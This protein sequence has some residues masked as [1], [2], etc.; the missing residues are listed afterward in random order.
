MWGMGQSWT[1][2]T[3]LRDGGKY[4]EK[5]IGRHGKIL[6]HYGFFYLKKVDFF[7]GSLFKNF[8]FLMCLL[9]KFYEY[10]IW[11]QHT[12]KRFSPF[13]VFIVPLTH[14]IYYVFMNGVGKP[15]AIHIQLNCNNQSLERYYKT[16]FQ[17]CIGT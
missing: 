12:I 14:S 8:E 6:R 4:M 13:F 5:L 1:C 17:D 3:N 16:P 9:L 15:M 10:C 7:L 11:S 2:M